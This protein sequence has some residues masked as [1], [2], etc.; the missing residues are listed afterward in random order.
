MEGLI[1]SLQKQ[2]IEK[3][4]E[5]SFADKVKLLIEEY[6][7]DTSKV[8]SSPNMSATEN[9][10]GDK[11]TISNQSQKGKK[12]RGLTAEDIE[13]L[14]GELVPLIENVTMKVEENERELNEKGNRVMVLEK[15]SRK[16]QEDI[17]DSKNDL[18]K[19]ALNLDK[20]GEESKAEDKKIF[21]EMKIRTS[22]RVWENKLS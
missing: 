2:M 20:L 22:D 5:H 7:N 21:D 19:I 16:H 3:V 12:R 15:H 11:K 4:D 8:E 10:D 6:D 17:E 14:K 9:E 1:E 18:R 13:L